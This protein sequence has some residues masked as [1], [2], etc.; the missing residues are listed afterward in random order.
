MVAAL[1]LLLAYAVASVWEAVF[2]RHVLH[3]SPAARRRWRRWGGAGALLRLAHFFHHG[4]HHQHTYRRSLL[5]QFDAPGQQ[6][7]LD[8]RLPAAVARRARSDRYGLTV[9][10]P[11]ELLAFTAVPLALTTAVAAVACPSMLGAGVGVSVLPLL[12]SRYVHPLLH[13]PPQAVGWLGRSRAFRFLQRYHLT[14]HRLGGRNYNLLPGGDLV[15]GQWHRPR[16]G[17]R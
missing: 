12:L 10:G 14:H 2:H 13:R 3:A 8:A 7:R 9:T 5:V 17:G 1:Y 16:R 11:C 4:I 15:M 6:Q